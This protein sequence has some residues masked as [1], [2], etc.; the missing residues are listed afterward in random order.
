M[1]T[2]N[3]ILK[4]LG[5]TLGANPNTLKTTDKTL[6]G[7][8]NGAWE[9]A[10]PVGSY[11]ET[12]DSLFTPSTT[13]GGTW[14]METLERDIVQCGETDSGTNVASGS[15][16]DVSFT[17]ST[18]FPSKPEI[19]VGFYSTSGAG[20]FGRCGIAVSAESTTGFTARIFN[21]D[22]SSRSPSIR[23]IATVKGATFYRWHR[24]A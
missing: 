4:F 23:W 7:G 21:G 3:S 20:T 6:V 18:E 13:W 24:T 12:S 1:N 9:I 8:I 16:A 17:F 11:Y 15:Y 10:Y 14:T 19:V 22:T 2:L 5:E